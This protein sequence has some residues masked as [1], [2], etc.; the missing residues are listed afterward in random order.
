MITPGELQ[1]GLTLRRSG[2][3][4]ALSR[5]LV[6][7]LATAGIAAAVC[8]APA[9]AR[10]QNSSLW[11]Q[12]RLQGPLTLQNSSWFY[13]EVEPPREIRLNDIVTII[14]DEKAQ[15]LS[16][17]EIDRRNRS[18]IDARL[19]DWIELNGL[20]IKPAPQNDGDP[21]VRGF[22]N[23]QMRA[24]AG[25]EA[26]EGMKLR[27]AAYVVDIRP[28]G[29]LVIEAH[30]RIRH[31][32]SMWHQSLTGVVRRE[33]ILPNN[34][35]FSEDV[36]ELHIDKFETGEVRDGYKRGWLLKFIDT[37]RPF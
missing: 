34:T 33:D 29:N 27:I 32:D 23:S 24:E 9:D 11:A 6:R 15:V 35:V 4:S 8:G 1:T 13:I 19:Q 37:V 5:Q 18:N 21:R 14:V 31:N 28:N 22:L 36:A 30:R 2:A 16:E 17:G 26:I 10:A 20:N 3:F 7:A 12:P 25:M